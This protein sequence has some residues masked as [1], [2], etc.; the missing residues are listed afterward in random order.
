[1]VRHIHDPFSNHLSQ[2]RSQL[3]APIQCRNIISTTYTLPAHKHVG[4]SA[5]PRALCEEGLQIRPK[6]VLVQ[7]DYERFRLDRVVFQQDQLGFLT[8]GAVGFGED[9]HWEL[10]VLDTGKK[11]KTEAR[12]KETYLEHA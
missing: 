2:R 8:V 10:L 1:M 9:D 4:H 5:T 6:R 11:W 3:V 12:W 7:F